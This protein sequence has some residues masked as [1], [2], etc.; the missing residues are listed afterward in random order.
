M[1]DKWDKALRKKIKDDEK[2]KGK[3]E[4]RLSNETFDVDLHNMQV[5]YA[6][7]EIKQIYKELAD[8]ERAD[9]E[10]Y[11]KIERKYGRTNQTR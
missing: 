8:L 6:L 9:L 2:K 11:N 4:T 10:D 3:F 7:P 1:F 5:G